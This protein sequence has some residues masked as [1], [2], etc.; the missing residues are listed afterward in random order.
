METL[1]RVPA[2]RLKLAAT[3]FVEAAPIGSFQ[4]LMRKSSLGPVCNLD[5]LLCESLSPSISAL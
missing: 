2:G 1:C 4:P 5:D 3:V